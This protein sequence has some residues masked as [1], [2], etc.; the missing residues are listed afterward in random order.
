MPELSCD[1]AIEILEPYIDRLW[2]CGSLP[3]RDYI[4]NYPNQSVHRVSTRAGIVH[5][6]MIS[7]MRD[8]FEGVTGTRIIEPDS[9]DL[10][11]LEIDERILLRFKK[12]TDDKLT[13]NY[14]T[15]HARDYDRG[16][17]L[18]GIP[19]ASQRMTLGYRLNRLQTG[20]RDVLV[21]YAVGKELVYAIVLEEPQTGI[22][23]VP[24]G[25]SPPPSESQPSRV[26]IRAT[27][28][29][30]KLEI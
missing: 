15:R 24:S 20:V 3:Y 1:D 7:H 5:D 28:F 26:R 16:Q 13:R 14:P 23:E 17:D 21:T 19:P 4:E 18:P 8:E 9:V 2:R 12:L 30:R 11:L 10:T 25:G 29:Q 22:A 27:E 6:L